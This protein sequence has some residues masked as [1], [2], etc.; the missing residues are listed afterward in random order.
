MS[1]GIAASINNLNR[2]AAR[3]LGANQHSSPQR[4][5]AAAI[6]FPRLLLK[7]HRWGKLWQAVPPVGWTRTVLH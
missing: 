4:V 5:R 7:N 3:P 2:T 6:Q 1:L